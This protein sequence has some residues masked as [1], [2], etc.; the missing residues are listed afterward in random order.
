M[1]MTENKYEFLKPHEI[2]PQGWLYRQLRTEADGLSGN[3]DKIW[4]DVRDSRWIGGSCEGWERV[5]YWLDGFIPL[6]YLLRDDDMI[7]RAQR[8]IDAI[9]AGQCEDGW[10]CPCKE[11]ERAEY[12]MWALLLITKVL[13][14]Y[15]DANP[16]EETRIMDAI[17]RAIRQAIDHLQAHPLFGWGQHRWY[18]GLIAAS[19][20]Y[21]RTHEEWSLDYCD[22]LHE[23]G[24]DYIHFI[25]ECKDEYEVPVKQWQW[26]THVVNLAMSLK[27]DALWQKRI[28]G[29]VSDTASRRLY[30][31]L[32]RYH[33]L[34]MGHFTGDECLAGRSPIQGTELC[35]VVE[36]MY[37]HEWL[38]ALTGNPAWGDILERLAFNALPAAI[39]TD[40]WTHQYDQQINQIACV[41]E[42]N[43][44]AVFGSNGPEAN[45]FGLEPNYGCC[46]ANMPQGF[47]KYALSVFMKND[48]AIFSASPVPSEVCVTLHNVAVTVA[49]ESAY[50]FRDAYTYRVSVDAPVT[51]SLDIRVP[52]FAKTA[53]IDGVSVTPGTVCT[54]RREWVGETVISVSLDFDV[55]LDPAGYEDLLCVNRGALLFSLPIG[56]DRK[57]LE[58]ERGGVER[59][60]PYCD[61]NLFPTEH[62]G[63]AF[64]GNDFSFASAK[65]IPDDVPVF[66]AQCPPVTVRASLAPIDWGTEDGFA[67]IAAKMP[68]DRTP[69]GDAAAMTLIPYGCT[70]LRMTAMPKL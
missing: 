69:I 60:F 9:L 20:L 67:Y 58:Y 10:I 13:V 26:N 3:L 45:T 27:S 14:V 66:S 12:D 5:P 63:Y 22:L 33:G 11:D 47:P 23:Q 65:T 59:K 24:R 42:E 48:D 53:V 15:A 50:P 4:P 61:Y 6:A 17:S 1:A 25:D 30:E 56:T 21:E 38:L 55:T 28:G 31:T 51:F 16:A 43:G 44:K 64:A 68:H 18:E 57:M 8:Y 36:A 34:P 7:M 37:S 41:P 35:G 2:K 32:M 29:A 70:D 62:W 39:S 46:T 54:L 52:G 40:M 19:R 49:C